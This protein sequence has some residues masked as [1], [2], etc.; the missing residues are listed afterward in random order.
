MFSVIVNRGT[1]IRLTML[2]IRRFLAILVIPDSIE[3]SPVSVDICVNWIY[4]VFSNEC[5]P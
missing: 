5:R 2:I 4:K 3:T 1:F